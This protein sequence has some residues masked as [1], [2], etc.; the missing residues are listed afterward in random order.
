MF[1]IFFLTSKGQL[2]FTGE[3]EA[4]NTNDTISNTKNDITMGSKVR[5]FFLKRKGFQLSIFFP[6]CLKGG[7][8]MLDF[9]C[10]T[11]PM[12]FFKYLLELEGKLAMRYLYYVS[13]LDLELDHP[14]TDETLPHVCQLIRKKIRGTDLI[15]R[16][17][18]KRFW[19]ILPF[20]EGED[21]F[22]VAERVRGFIEKDIDTP[23]SKPVDRTVSIGGACFPTHS[24]DIAHLLCTADRM[25][26]LAKANGGNKVSFPDR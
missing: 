3:E 25:L 26:F 19:V 20:V 8:P 15:A 23:K 12:N 14:E 17:D 4:K 5:R 9:H 11:V 18:D 6:F 16:R 13:F 21:A 24:P 10:P 22:C 1:D 2:L 7:D